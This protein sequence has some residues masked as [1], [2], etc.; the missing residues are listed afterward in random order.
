MANDSVLFGQ[1]LK[2]ADITMSHKK[3]KKL[4]LQNTLF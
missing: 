4:M 3:L 2:A 1:C